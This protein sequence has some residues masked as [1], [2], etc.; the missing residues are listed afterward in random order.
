V[1]GA[2]IA[3]DPGLVDEVG[4]VLHVQ[5]TEPQARWTVDLA[6]APGSVTE[7]FSERADVLLTLSDVDLEKLARGHMSAA[8]A[9]QRGLLRVD[10][11]VEVARRLGFMSKLLG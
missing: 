2:R 1:L 4:A 8:E 3:D 9:F 7:G 10:G 6:S 5:V 11:K